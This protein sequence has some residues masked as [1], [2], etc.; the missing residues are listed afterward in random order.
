M[1]STALTGLIIGLIVVVG[2][3]AY[4]LYGYH[5]ASPGV[6][7]TGGVAPN[8][9][10]SDGSGGSF[11]TSSTTTTVTTTFPTVSAPLA[12]TRAAM[13]ITASFATLRGDVTPN[14]AATRY[15][16]EY[17]TSPLLTSAQVHTTP[18]FSLA[19]ST[20]EAA[21][22]VDVS[23]LRGNTTYYF[24]IVAQNSAGLVRGSILSFDTV[25]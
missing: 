21:V 4:L 3:A 16:F 10:T 12:S 25:R 19:T 23:N 8:G 1:N 14:G 18:H 24:R 7:N 6:P 5:P 9:A 20:N 11:L 15:W 13:S 22:S 17:G 2:G